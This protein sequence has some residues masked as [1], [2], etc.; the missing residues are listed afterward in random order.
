MHPHIPDLSIVW[1][2]LGK[3]LSLRRFPPDEERQFRQFYTE[4]T[5]P[6]A[7]YGVVFGL[8]VW[9]SFALWDG[10]AFPRLLPELFAIRLGLGT[11][12]IA[13]LAWFV[14]HHPQ[15]FKAHM[16]G[17]L[18]IALIGLTLAL[19]S[20]MLWAGS[21]A[22][23][24]AFQHFWP[25]YSGL[26]FF[27]YAF[28]GLR[29]LPAAA[30]GL[31][32]LGL[33]WIGGWR[34]G[35][36]AAPLGRASLQLAILNMLGIIVCARQ[37][38]QERTLF[39]LKQHHR[40]LAQIG[41]Q[42]RQSLQEARDETL[43]EN[44]RA[45]AALMLA[46]SEREKL[47]AAIAEK[48]RFLSAAYHD[49]QQPLSTIG[50]YARLAK[51]KLGDDAGGELGVIENAATDI[52]LMFK[53][54]RDIWEIGRVAPGIEAVDLAAVFDEI[55]RELRERADLKGLAFRV[56]PPSQ[57]AAWVRSD[58]TL[59]KRALSNLV[60]N[61]IKYTEQGGVLVGAV[62]FGTRVRIDVWDT[63]IGI[64]PQLQERIFEEYFQIGNANNSPKQGLGLGLAIV[65]RIERNLP[66][67]Q[68]RLTSRLRHGSRFS[69]TLPAVPGYCPATA[70]PTL[71]LDD[72]NRLLQGKYIVVI[73]DDLD[74]LDG[75]VRAISETGCIV[76]GVDGA[77]A[78]RR[79]FAQR[80]RC[81]DVLVSDFLLGQGQTGL[82][83]VAAL[84][85]RFDWAMEVPVLF[86]T[87]GLQAQAQLA[88]FQGVYE[89]HPKPILL[90][91]LL[92]ALRR[93]IKPPV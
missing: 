43:Q 60:R 7:R 87:G 74:N 11:A 90:D 76:E 9:V 56:R 71:G 12:L 45:E 41:R 13:A 34:L 18:S 25:T 35:V 78:A 5:Y 8:V 67:H 22:P 85:E 38:T 80:E 36:A 24:Q 3:R 82:D 84:R 19:F 48:E 28:L 46:K 68:L 77:D 54:V 61:A 52:A 93:L 50:L 51:S 65:R 15:H 69:L 27:L 14:I 55:E 4:K 86:V 63:G 26:L 23:N 81:P 83:A 31:L 73:E 59:L 66:G 72:A 1:L 62:G 40:R 30:V 49:L 37:E 75:L 92:A 47:D 58:R 53:G 91:A 2:R 21:V 33:V 64:P 10:L 17:W 29:T 79:L 44:A 42:A 88:N 70:I 6:K 57:A 16:Q 32:S 89:I 20:M 39:R